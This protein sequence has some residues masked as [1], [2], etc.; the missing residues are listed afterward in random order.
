MIPSVFETIPEEGEPCPENMSLK[1]EPS[2]GEVSLNESGH[3][4]NVSTDDS[5]S[6]F[7]AK[8]KGD[9]TD[10]LREMNSVIK[11]RS[12]SPFRDYRRMSK[13]FEMPDSFHHNENDDDLDLV[14]VDLPVTPKSLRSAS[15]LT[16]V[17]QS[18]F[19]CLRGTNPRLSASNL[20]F[21]EAEASVH[22]ELNDT[23]M[24]QHVLAELNAIKESVSSQTSPNENLHTKLI[25]KSTAL[26]TA[27][28]EITKLRKDSDIRMTM[29]EKENTEKADKIAALEAK[30][31]TTEKER[32]CL[33]T[34]GKMPEDPFVSAYTAVVANSSELTIQK[35]ILTKAL[36]CVSNSERRTAEALSAILA[37]LPKEESDYVTGTGDTLFFDH[38]ITEL[39]SK[40]AT[41]TQ[42]RN[43]L[44]TEVND[45]RIEL[46]GC[47]RQLAEAR[48]VINKQQDTVSRLER[49]YHNT[50]DV[51][52]DLQQENGSLAKRLNE[53]LIVSD[54]DS[55]QEQTDS[56]PSSPKLK[57]RTGS[58]RFKSPFRKSKREGKE[59]K[60][61]IKTPSS[62]KDDPR[63]EDTATCHQQ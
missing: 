14:E 9:R 23:N 38:R 2:S 47:Q 34:R 29:L 26:A 27:Q 57:S 33:V 19:Q 58:I 7:K 6:S 36:E 22:S 5:G 53:T 59:S 24:Y 40:L 63:T 18:R 50:S 4:E 28:A 30:L 10:V 32:D 13:A 51:I 15:P 60:E 45:L 16:P 37:S 25:E 35:D 48:N 56:Q 49:E 62:P 43:L 3:G 21:L 52:F 11:N 46:A 20:S 1:D 55:L 44:R 12:A 8:P 17:R 31:R 42:E 61:L 41:V 39:E 54:N